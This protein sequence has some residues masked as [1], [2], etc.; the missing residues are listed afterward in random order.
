[1]LNSLYGR[2]GVSPYLD[3]HIIINS[4]DL[5]DLSEK[6]NITNVLSLSQDKE[7]V[8]YQSNLQIE[9]ENNNTLC[10]IAIAAAVT[11][12]ARVFRS[13]FKNMPEYT[14]YYSDTDSLV[15]DSSFLDSNWIGKN[16]GQFKLEYFIDEAYFISNKTYC[17]ILKNGETIIKTKG[18]INNSITIEDF[19]SMYWF[20]KNITAR[21]Y[22][23][24][25]NYEKASV[26]IEKKD[27]I[28]NYDSY[29]KREKIY[30]LEG[31]W[32]ETKPLLLLR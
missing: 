30:N 20:N 19:K 4:K 16:I 27:V 9:I 15:L 12:G 29:T 17:L 24:K 1:M 8:S 14:L 7:L 22:N 3:K 13:K 10:N 26:L 21:K 2:F 11:A 31:I 5:V 25:T 32:V 18:V 23:S 6:E 28:L